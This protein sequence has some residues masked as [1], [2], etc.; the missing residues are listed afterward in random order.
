LEAGKFVQQ[1]EGRFTGLNS[2]TVQ[3]VDVIF[4]GSVESLLLRGQ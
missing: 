3:Q 2:K 1:V 4:I